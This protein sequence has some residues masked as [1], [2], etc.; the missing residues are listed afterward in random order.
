MNTQLVTS[1][2][3]QKRHASR[4]KMSSSHRGFLV[5]MFL[6]TIS[7][8]LIVFRIDRATKPVRFTC[9]RTGFANHLY[10][11]ASAKTLLH[12]LYSLRSASSSRPALPSNLQQQ[13]DFC[14]RDPS[15]YSSG[16]H[17]TIIFAQMAEALRVWGSLRHGTQ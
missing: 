6:V 15:P 13:H 12:C 3:Q 16:L 1:S 9:F 2:E 14:I 11:L 7:V 4:H 8:R 5:H 17:S 10:L